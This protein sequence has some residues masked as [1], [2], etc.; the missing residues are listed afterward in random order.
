MVVTSDR[1]VMDAAARAGVTA[2]A[3]REFEERVRRARSAPAQAPGMRG[4][5]DDGDDPSPRGTK[6]KGPSHRTSKRERLKQR[7]M[8]KL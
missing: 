3:S 5:D 1:P 7:G 8:E 6:K 4:K 2:I